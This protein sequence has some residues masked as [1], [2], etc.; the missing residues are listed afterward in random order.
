MERVI[1]FN[2]RTE[3]SFTYCKWTACKGPTGNNGGAIFSE[4]AEVSLSF[5]GCTFLDCS[6]DDSQHGGIIYASQI[7]SISLTD[8]FFEWTSS[9]NKQAYRGGALY[10][11]TIPSVTINHDTF[12][13]CYATF[14]GGAIWS[15]NCLTESTT[16]QVINNCRFITCRGVSDCGGSI[17]VDSKQYDNLITNS[18]FSDCSNFHAG[19]LWLNSDCYSSHS[20]NKY[21]LKHCFFNRN[22]ISDTSGYGNDAIIRATAAYTP[23]DAEPVFFCCFSTSDSNRVGYRKYNTINGKTE[24]TSKNVNWL[25]Q[26]NINLQLIR[27]VQLMHI[28]STTHTLTLTGRH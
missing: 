8:T 16:K 1:C 19:A 21:P 18:L 17:H 27:G 14:S 5:D 7:S 10:L 11:H 4:A 6:C 20:P 9:V 28:Q 23:T 3:Y 2:T 12:N 24:W 22:Y 13:K 15:Y 26:A 25:P